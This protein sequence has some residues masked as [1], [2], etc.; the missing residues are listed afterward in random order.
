MSA[1]FIVSVT[2][3]NSANRKSYDDYIAR[4]WS[5]AKGY[6]GEYLVRSEDIRHVASE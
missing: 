4:V 6:D 1:H 5:I 2:F 3:P